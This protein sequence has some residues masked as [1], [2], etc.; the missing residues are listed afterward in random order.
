MERRITQ[1]EIEKQALSQEEEARARDRLRGIEEEL[2][3]LVGRYTR[4][5]TD[6]EVGLLGGRLLAAVTYKASFPTQD[7]PPPPP[8]PPATLAMCAK[9]QLI[10]LDGMMKDMTAEVIRKEDGS[11]GWVRA[12]GRIHIRQE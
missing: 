7:V 11:I 5:M 6:L 4:P 1:L 3:E 2:A 9:D 8:P 12:G 10:I